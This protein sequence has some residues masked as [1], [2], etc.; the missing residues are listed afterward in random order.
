MIETRE[1]IEYM[2]REPKDAERVCFQDMIS[3]F[4]HFEKTDHYEKVKLLR[5]A[6]YLLESECDEME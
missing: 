2:A 4:L 6:Y 3:E 1:F 5:A